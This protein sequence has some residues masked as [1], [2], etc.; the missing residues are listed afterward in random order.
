ME[1]MT[2]KK[3][4]P[5][6][7]LNTPEGAKGRLRQIRGRQ[8]YSIVRKILY[9]IV[10]A[11][12]AWSTDG[13]YGLGLLL[14]RGAHFVTQRWS[15]FLRQAA[16]VDSPMRRTIHHEDAETVFGGVQGQGRA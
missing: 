9:L 1:S 16:K 3:R 14:P 13:C 2:Q 15:H 5:N 11:N 12:R 8:P 6:T 7:A 10:A 4:A